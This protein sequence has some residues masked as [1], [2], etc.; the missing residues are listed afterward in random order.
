MKLMAEPGRTVLG[1]VDQF[2]P[3]IL[4]N[5]DPTCR[6]L[7]GFWTTRHD[8]AQEGVDVVINFIEGTSMNIFF[9]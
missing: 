5:L 2:M 8:P 9:I 3:C 4:E 7:V 1:S 6:L